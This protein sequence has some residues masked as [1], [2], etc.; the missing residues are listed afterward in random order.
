MEVR[1]LSRVKAGEPIPHGVPMH[2]LS[3]EQNWSDAAELGGLGA[4]FDQDM[5]N[6]RFVQ[7]GLHAS[8]TGLVQL[9]DYQ[10]VRIRQFHQTLD[11]Y[12]SGAIGS[13]G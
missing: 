8:K 4:V 10:E 6:L 13:E 11:K 1:V 5:G 3:L 9:A 12:L 7:E 2:R